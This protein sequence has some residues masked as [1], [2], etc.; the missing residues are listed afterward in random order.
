MA[1]NLKVVTQINK[2]FEQRS[3]NPGFPNG[4]VVQ[5]YKAKDKY[6]TGK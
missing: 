2:L 1:L 5:S 4:G 3:E 6:E